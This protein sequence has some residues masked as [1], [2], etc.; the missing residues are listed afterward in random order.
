MALVSIVALGV[1]IYRYFVHGIPVPGWGSM[2]FSLYFIAG[3]LFANLGLI[4]IYLGRVFAESRN[5]PLYVVSGT[6]NLAVG[7]ADVLE[8]EER[9]GVAPVLE[10]DIRHR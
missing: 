4:G 8:K 1:L 10:Y 2:I 7:E 9:L 6:Q 3:L 5:R